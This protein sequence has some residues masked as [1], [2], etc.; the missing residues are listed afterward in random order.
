MIVDPPSLIRRSALCVAVGIL[1][2]FPRL[3]NA[4]E[5]SDKTNSVKQSDGILAAEQKQPSRFFR[6]YRPGETIGGSDILN[7]RSSTPA[8][9]Q[10]PAPPSSKRTDELLDR[11]RNWIFLT[12]DEKEPDPTKEAFGVDESS[13]EAR[14][15]VITRFL[16]NKP[17]DELTTN[18]GQTGEIKSSL[19]MQPVT[20]SWNSWLESEAQDEPRRGGSLQPVPL[21]RNLSGSAAERA[22]FADVWRERYG[23]NSSEAREEKLAESKAFL[24]LFNSRSGAPASVGIT[25]FSDPAISGGALGVPGGRGVGP[26]PNPGSFTSSLDP[27]REAPRPIVG[28]S[29]ILTEPGFNSKVF[30]PTAAPVLK[31]EAPKPVAQPAVLP[32]PKRAF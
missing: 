11:Q 5:S 16:E 10:N 18:L 19:S 15:S 7:S 17:A 25:G 8:R 4:G 6:P 29:S 2:A 27:F 14:K 28:G 26:V 13:L 20:S 9:Y 12:G 23:V 24:D 32:F 3:G 21:E 30:N 31:Q 1:V 22:K